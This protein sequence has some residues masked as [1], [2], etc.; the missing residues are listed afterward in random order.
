M[1]HGMTGCDQVTMYPRSGG[2]RVAGRWV[3]LGLAVWL[4]GAAQAMVAMSDDEMSTQSG[5]GIAIAFQNLDFLMAPTSYIEATPSTTDVPTGYYAADLR[6]YGLS[7]T[8]DS[9]ADY[10]QWNGSCASISGAGNIC[11]VGSAGVVDFA[12]VYNPFVLRVFNYAGYDAAGGDL[13]QGS[14]GTAPTVLELR[15]PTASDSWLWSF[16]GALTVNATT[17]G[18]QT[19]GVVP[20]TGT[21]P[22]GGNTTYC[23]LQSMVIIDGK[24]I[25]QVDST[26]GSYTTAVA[27]PTVFQMFTMPAVTDNYGSGDVTFAL[28]YDSALSGNWR[29]G[30]EQAN[31]STNTNVT[32]VP[33]FDQ[34]EG[35]YFK[36]VNA[37]LP[38]GHLNDQA[39][40]FNAA[41]VT[42]TNSPSGSGN[43]TVELTRVPNV[44]NAY[45]DIY[46]GATTCST[47]ANGAIASPNSQ[48]HGFVDWGTTAGMTGYGSPAGATGTNYNDIT[49]TNTTQGIYFDD[50]TTA[51]QTTAGTIT[52]I[53]TAH[54]DG[55][56]FQHLMITT[57]GAGSSGATC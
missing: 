52:N 28:V 34:Q 54:I 2:V 24:P 35:M 31:G 27:T 13:T 23:G 15:G 51:S 25:A 10:G 7:M 49:G 39:I 57:C 21:C 14:T 8:N 36:N 45:N 37:Y 46:C 50:P 9:T 42:T 3:F 32:T 17:N 47:D 55:V 40:V 26:Y 20:P 18:P 5:G 22:T 4:S 53:G 6:W 44:A 33:S 56:L 38:L 30:V 1:K 19:V 16:W 41:G 43:F 11:P 29:F 48:T 12:S